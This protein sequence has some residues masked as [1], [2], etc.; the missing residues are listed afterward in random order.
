MAV[1]N[2]LLSEYTNNHGCISDYRGNWFSSVCVMC[3]AYQVHRST[4]MQRLKEGHTLKESLLGYKYP[5]K[6]PTVV[7]DAI[8]FKGEY[9][10]SLSKLAVLEGVNPSL[11]IKK[12]VEGLSP[13]EAINFIHNK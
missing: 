12:V 5:R 6:E 10:S 13:E 8:P 2:K 11:L 7:G 9:Y 1:T 3:D 4:F